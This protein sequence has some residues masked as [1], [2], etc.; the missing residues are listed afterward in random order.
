MRKMLILLPDGRIHKLRLPWLH[1]VSFR[2]APLTGTTLAALVPP[3]LGF[4]VRLCDASID[5][6]PLQEAFDLVAISLITG[7]APGGYALADHFRSRGATVVLGGVHVTLLPDEARQ[8][9]DAIVLGFA[10]RSWPRLCRDFVAGRLQ[11]EYR[12][13]G[14]VRG[15]PHPRRDLQRRFGYMVP[16]TVFATR[17][18]RNHCDFCAVIAARFGWHMRPVGEVVDEIKALPGRRFAFNDVNLCDDRDYALELFQ[19][20]KPLKKS[21][22]GLM[23]TKATADDE[24]MDALAASGCVYMLLGFES[25]NRHGLYAMRKGFNNAEHYP[26]VCDALHRRGLLIQ[27]CFIFGL[28]DDGPEVFEETVEAVNALQIDIPRYALST[29]FPGTALHER[30]AAEG[31]LL[32]K[33]WDYYDT[34]HVVLQ[35]KRMSPEELD[36]GFIRAWEKTFTLR[37]IRHRTTPRRRLYAGALAGNFAYWLY[38]RRLRRDRLRFPEPSARLSARG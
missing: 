16:Q 23:S 13:E 15:L 20:L 30:F 33:R 21:W 11:A 5:R 12:E 17:G 35:P 10:E 19:A 2:E 1:H 9:A 31:R 34:Q 7:N 38:V 22:G 3:D 32:H 36:C 37:S 4:D 8:H 29:P 27:G 6:V 25:V 14:E 18:C 28:D 26:S 24:L